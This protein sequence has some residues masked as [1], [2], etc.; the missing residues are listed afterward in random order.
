MRN[1]K[2]HC[3]VR[4]FA[5]VCAL[6]IA[7]YGHFVSIA[8]SRLDNSL[9]NQDK[10]T[11]TGTVAYR[12]RI[13][14]PPGAVVH[15]ELIDPSKADAKATVIAEQKIETQGKQVPIPFTLT[16]D[17]AQINER[18]LYQVQAKIMDGDTLRYRNTQAYPVIT[19]GNPTKIVILVAPASSSGTGGTGKATIRGMYSYMADA[20]ILTDCRTG[21]KY[22]V[23]QEGDNA[24]L[25]RAYA[26][27]RKNPGEPVLVTVEGRIASRPKMEGSG[28]EEKV[29]VDRFRSFTPGGA[30]EQ[31]QSAAKLENTRWKLVELNGNPVTPVSPRQEA[32]LELESKGKRLAGSGGCNKILGGYEL[33]GDQLR[34]T[35][36][37]STR[38]AC[39]KGMETEQEF[40]KALEATTGFKLSGDNLELYA[41]GKLLAKLESKRVK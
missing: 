24:A 1:S 17:P 16:Y 6:M 11:V 37:A 2:F 38:M 34:F 27:V 9:T 32:Y 36:V 13:A 26:K 30:C 19:R 33:T 22:P 12:Q 23:A 40:L 41:D 18:N 8:G 7:G 20:G 28:E 15:V 39:I 14:L 35:K 4:T 10:G 25:E 21:K 5:A 31:N 29:I 3:T